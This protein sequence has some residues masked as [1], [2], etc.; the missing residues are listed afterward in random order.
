MNQGK[1]WRVVNPTVGVPMF[2]GA[3]AVSSFAVHYMLYTHT[4]WFPAYHEGG[5]KSVPAKTAEAPATLPTLTA[6]AA[7]PSKQ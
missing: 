7:T 3:V 2:L 5:M 6:Q 4:K 1:I